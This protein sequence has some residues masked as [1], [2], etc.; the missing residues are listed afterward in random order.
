MVRPV[1]HPLA[2][3]RRINLGELKTMFF[4]G[5]SEKSHPGFQ[6]ENEARPREERTPDG[7]EF[8]GNSYP[9]R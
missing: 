6:G 1:K 7:G 2:L 8:G 4:V 9:N 3:K 5:M